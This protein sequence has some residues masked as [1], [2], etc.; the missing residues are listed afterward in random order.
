MGARVY[1]RGVGAWCM[2]WVHG[3]V[4]ACVRVYVCMGTRVHVW[5]HGCMVRVH[6]WVHG[7]MVYEYSH[8]P[9]LLHCL[10]V[11]SCKS[12]T[13]RVVDWQGNG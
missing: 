10:I 4:D 6:V 13:C 12:H 1:V 8:G 7:C 3:C 2:A 11:H 9:S 5:V